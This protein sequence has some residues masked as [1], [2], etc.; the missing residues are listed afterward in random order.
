MSIN[1]GEVKLR[2]DDFPYAIMVLRSEEI[3]QLPSGVTATLVVS[4]GQNKEADGTFDGSRL[5]LTGVVFRI[6]VALGELTL[7]Q[8]KQGLSPL[9]D[10]ELSDLKIET[11][12]PLTQGAITLHLET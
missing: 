4:G 11:T 8:I 12:K 7:D 3:P 9:V 5:M 10:F 2:M 1:D 6:R